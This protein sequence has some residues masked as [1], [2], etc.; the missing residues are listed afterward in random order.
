[1]IQSE[2]QVRLAMPEVDFGFDP[3]P[4]MADMVRRIE[5]EGDPIV[6]VRYKGGIAWMVLGYDHASALFR[7]ESEIPAAPFFHREMETLGTSLFHKQGDDHR[8]YKMAVGKRFTPMAVRQMVERLLVPTA[9]AIIDDFGEARE[10]ELYESY[11]KRYGF[12]VISRLIDVPVT[13]DQESD[14]IDMINALNQIREPLL[15]R[16]EKKRRAVDARQ[17]TNALLQPL[18]DARRKAP[19]EDLISYFI[20]LEVD[21]DHLNDDEI[22]DFIRSIYLAGADST[23]LQLNLIMN[24]IL[25][26]PELYGALMAH[27]EKRMAAIDEIM[28][29]DSVSGIN[30]RV[31]SKDTEIAGVTVPADS[32]VL[33]C[34]PAANRSAEQ[35]PDPDTFSLERPQRSPALTFGAGVHL[36]LGRNLARE[37]LRISVDRLLDRL[38]GLRAADGP[39]QATGTLFRVLPEGLKV[40]FDG[41]LPAAA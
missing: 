16:E 11:G 39:Q 20:D 17:P 10:V 8:A 23:G 32:L 7:N 12:N 14:L 5:A 3:L 6:Q 35:F 29:L 19:G 27:P 21:G 9:D 33:L 24:Y 22:M 18:I 28:R 31:T 37:E 36:C 1:M 34:T 26:R 30:S 2:T 15:S 4:D 38:P 40:R 13:R 41:I 25:A